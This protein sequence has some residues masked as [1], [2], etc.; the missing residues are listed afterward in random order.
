MKWL[1]WKERLSDWGAKSLN[2]IK[3]LSSWGAKRFNWNEIRSN[4]TVLYVVAALI[5]ILIS[6]PVILWTN[7]KNAGKG[8]RSGPVT[9]SRMDTGGRPD[10]RDFHE[11]QGG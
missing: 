8:P 6:V 1:G 2:G 3:V 5:V 10:G 11:S 7:R 9:D 4:R